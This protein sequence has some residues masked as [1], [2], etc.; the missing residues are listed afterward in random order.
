MSQFLKFVKYSGN[1][2]DFIILDHPEMPLGVE[3]I[4]RLCDRQFGV[5][6]DGVL[7]LTSYETTDGRMQIFNADGGEAE[8]CGNGLRCLATYVDHKLEKKKTSYMIKTMNHLYNIQKTHSG[9]QIEMNEISDVN[10]KDLGWIKDFVQVFYV[11]TG[12]PHLV[13]LSKDVKKI[14]LKK[15]APFYRFNSHFKNGA[16]VNFVEVSDE[17]SQIAYVRTFERGVEDETFS[18]GTGLTATGLALQHWFGWKGEITLKTKGG[19]QIVTI[20]DQVFYSG[21][22][23]FCFQGEFPV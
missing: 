3:L 1:G 18:C 14:D 20:G 16:N 6:A 7:V 23:S 17:L 19:N 4:K 9:M 2:N 11:N 10:S 15:E 5:G 22:V 13:L 21:D 8:M 12:V